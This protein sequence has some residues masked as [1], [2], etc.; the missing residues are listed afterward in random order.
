MAVT[1]KQL[2]EALGLRQ[3]T[4][5]DLDRLVQGAC[6]C[7]LL[8][9]VMARGEEGMAWITVHT[10]LNVLAV[11]SLHDFS[12]VLFPEGIAPGE[13]IIAKAQEEDIP[14]LSYSGTAYALCCRLCEMG[15]E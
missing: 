6:V 3:F 15:V 8:S 11:A 7:D 12:C 10:N 2:Q 9:W 14:L 1:V 5:L 13:E 4:D